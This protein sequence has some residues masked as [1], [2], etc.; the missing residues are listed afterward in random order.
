M[1]S[2]RNTRPPLSVKNSGCAP[3]EDYNISVHDC[4]NLEHNN[5]V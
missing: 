2:L 3:E 5:Q 1:N 4:E